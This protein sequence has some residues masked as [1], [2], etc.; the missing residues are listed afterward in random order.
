MTRTLPALPGRS[1]V[2]YRWLALV[3]AVAVLTTTSV[4]DSS[5]GT[6]IAQSEAEIAA[7]SSRLAHLSQLSETTANAYDNA[8][9]EL[10]ATARRINVL[11]GQLRSSR[12][13]LARASHD[14]ATAVIHYYVMG[15]VTERMPPIFNQSATQQV[16]RALYE[17]L[18]LARMSRLRSNYERDR[19]SLE[20]SV[21]EVQRQRNQLRQRSIQ[22]RALLVQNNLSVAESRATLATI[23]HSLA[24]KIIAY[25]IQRGVQA[26]KRHD[27]AGEIQAVTTASSVGGQSA[28]NT[29]TVAIQSAASAVVVT[30]IAPSAQ[31][32]AAV[33]Y[34]ESQ[35]GV[36]YVWGGESPGVGF[37]CSGLVQWAWGKVGVAIPRTTETQWPVLNHVSLLSLQPGDLLYYFNLDGDHLVD[38]LVMYVG[39]G[40][41]GVNTVIAAAH[42]GTTVS[43]AP[44]FTAGLI[45]AARP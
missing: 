32:L 15:P 21:G 17:R 7:L 1:R 9:A 16:A 29:V 13:A 31:G 40:P 37:D 44:L 8:T 20:V 38:H 43:Y 6:T 19:S 33:H 5:G 35:I 36:P 39:S 4:A 42:S 23:T 22:I 2:T 24:A 30:Q 41:Y 27:T 28:A 3:T 11:Q 12:S 34:A 18:S 10:A 45:G 26:A 25:E 14:L